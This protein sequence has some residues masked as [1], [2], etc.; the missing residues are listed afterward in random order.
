MRLRAIRTCYERAVGAA[1]LTGAVV[2][3]VTV[4]EGGRTAGAEVRED[5]LGDGNVNTCLIAL[6]RRWRFPADNAGVFDATL[7]FDPG[8]SAPL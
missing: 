2:L 1:H 4:D 3:R 6:A 7:E 5:T 8:T